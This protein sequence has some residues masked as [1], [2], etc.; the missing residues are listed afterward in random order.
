MEWKIKELHKFKTLVCADL[1]PCE[2]CTQTK[3]EIDNCYYEILGDLE[4]K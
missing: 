3:E 1:K 4:A 2:G